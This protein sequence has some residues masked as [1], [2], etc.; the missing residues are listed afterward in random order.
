MEHRSLEKL[1]HVFDCV[2]RSVENR[3]KS[4]DAKGFVI[5]NDNSGRG[6]NSTQN[7]VTASLAFHNETDPFERTD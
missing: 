4:A 6:I 7:D 5:G 3:A 1:E 2:S